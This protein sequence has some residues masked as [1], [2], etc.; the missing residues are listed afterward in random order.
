M[1]GRQLAV[2]DEFVYIPQY[3]GHTASLNVAVAASIVLQYFAVWACY[4]EQPREMEGRKFVVSASRGKL[5]AYR[6]PSEKELKIRQQLQR[7]RYTNKM[8]ANTVG[9]G[10]ISVDLLF[11]DG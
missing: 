10:E 2:C 5:E 4:P 9:D 8:L 6:H 1:N 7:A 3:S 11:N